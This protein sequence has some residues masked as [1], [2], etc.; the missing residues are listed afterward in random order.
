MRDTLKRIKPYIDGYV[1]YKGFYD[2]INIALPVFKATLKGLKLS[3]R[4]RL[5]IDAFLLA[6]E[7][8]NHTVKEYKEANNGY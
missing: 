4:A 6:I 7:W 1:C 3:K 8:A 2:D 5:E